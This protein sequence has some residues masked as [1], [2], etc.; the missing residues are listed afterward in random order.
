MEDWL[1]LLRISHLSHQVFSFFGSTTGCSTTT[2]CESGRFTSEAFFDKLNPFWTSIRP[3]SRCLDTWETQSV[4]RRLRKVIRYTKLF[5][6][7]H[8]WHMDLGLT[9]YHSSFI[10]D[11]DYLFFLCTRSFP[12]IA[13]PVNLPT[14]SL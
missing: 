9:P 4:A 2:L 1:T 11:G 8:T 5:G 13:R 14:A 12:E 6:N 7:C 10:N 3:V